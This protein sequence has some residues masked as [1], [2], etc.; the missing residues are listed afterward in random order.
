MALE[1]LSEVSVSELK[2]FEK[3]KYNLEEANQE[4]EIMK[5][6]LEEQAKQ[7]EDMEQSVDDASIAQQVVDQY[8]FIINIHRIL[9]IFIN[10]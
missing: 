5:Q 4:A 3:T 2:E 10:F 1:K 8:E 7:I 6:M 9:I